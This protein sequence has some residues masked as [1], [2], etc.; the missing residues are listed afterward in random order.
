MRSVAGKQSGGVA[1][2]RKGIKPVIRWKKTG[3]SCPHCG[4]EIEVLV[5]AVGDYDG[6]CSAERCWRC[7]WVAEL[8][9][10]KEVKRSEDSRS[11]RRTR[12]SERGP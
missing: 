3:N 6:I 5:G 12:T 8:D 2:W 9:K 7:G 10:E 11:V 1:S 4:H